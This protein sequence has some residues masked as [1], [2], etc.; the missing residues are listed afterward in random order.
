MKDQTQY[1]NNITLY[2]I[3]ATIVLHVLVILSFNLTKIQ[4][5]MTVFSDA[6]ILELDFKEPEEIEKMLLPPEQNID[7]SNQDIKDLMQDI[8]DIRKK[9]RTNFSE[10]RINQEIE[11]EVIERNNQS[12]NEKNKKKESGTN[13]SIK[14][15]PTKENETQ[16][17]SAEA[18]NS[19]AG[20]VTRYCNVQGRECYTVAPSYTCKG[21]G[22]VQIDIKV[23]KIGSVK[24]VKVNTANTTTTNECILNQAL[25]YAKRTTKVSSDLKG[26]HA[27]SGY[28][29]YNFVSQ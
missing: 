8:Q 17:K 19:Y 25:D 11:N 18:E 7:E 5:E 24:S 28:I 3:L 21:G 23:D 26:E 15:T 9:S 14:E 2:A 16:D 22:Q 12:L 4:S 20:K 1:R 10:S 29:I 6:A 27:N 13:S